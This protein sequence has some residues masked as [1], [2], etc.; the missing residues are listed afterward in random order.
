M[1]LGAGDPAWILWIRKT[2]VGMKKLF[3]KQKSKFS[4]SALSPSPR[5]SSQPRH[6]HGTLG[7]YVL[8]NQH[9]GSPADLLL[10]AWRLELPFQSCMAGNSF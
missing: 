9:S 1:Q 8:M 4:L 10:A 6:P 3:S 2:D 5:A 7:L